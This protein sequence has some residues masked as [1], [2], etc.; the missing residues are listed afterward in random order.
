MPELLASKRRCWERLIANWPAFLERRRNWLAQQERQGVA[1]EQAAERILEDLFTV[2]LDWTTADL[3]HQVQHADLLLSHNGMKYLLIEAKRPGALMW[4][5]RAIE[6]ALD[7]A[8]RYAEEQHVRI[9]AISDGI[10]LYAA[11]AEH[12]GLTDR[13][14]ASLDAT[15]PSETLWWLSMHGIYRDVSAPVD[16]APAL[17]PESPSAGDTPLS[18]PIGGELLH[19]KYHLPARC[20]AFAASAADPATWKLPFCLCDGR[21]DPRRLPKA[22]A[23]L[24]SN[25]RGTKV[26][27]IPDRDIPEV[28]IR[29]ARAAVQ[30]GKMPWQCAQ[31]APIYQQL[32]D[33]LE[34]LNRLEELKNVPG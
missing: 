3:N 34:Q 30:S 23:A 29:L 24:L 32:A 21:P 13:V 27:G 6:A 33:A 28:L 15:Q 20:F 12:G 31:P 25:Y 8:R 10:M 5:R 19:S 22:V 14:Y 2:A 11:N 26:R 1:P 16:A 18:V 4:N 17:L 7:Q 9:V